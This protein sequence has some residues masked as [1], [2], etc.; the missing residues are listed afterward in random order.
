MVIKL[1]LRGNEAFLKVNSAFLIGNKAFLMERMSSFNGNNAFLKGNKACRKLAFHF[2]ASVAQG[3]LKVGAV[4]KRGNPSLLFVSPLLLNSP[5]Q[6][7]P[8]VC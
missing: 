4:N 5:L 6:N 3:F 2:L 1:S 8:R 7:I